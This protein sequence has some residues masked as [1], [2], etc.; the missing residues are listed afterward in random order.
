MENFLFGYIVYVYIGI[1]DNNVYLGQLFLK[2]FS[3][4]GGMR[5]W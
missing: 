5:G 1:D 3:R 2:P 4:C